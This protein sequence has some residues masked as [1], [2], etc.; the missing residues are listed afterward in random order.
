[1]FRRFLIAMGTMLVVGCAQSQAIKTSP[2][3]D[4]PADASRS[5]AML[6]RLVGSWRLTGT[7]AG[8]SAVHDVDAE[9][10][11]QRSCV[12]INEVSR[13]RR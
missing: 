13:E 11:L 1:M 2:L 12:R 8:Q 3:D 4:A 7:I 6:G 5:E 10:T 9:W